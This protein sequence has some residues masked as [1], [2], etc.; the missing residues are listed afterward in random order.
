MYICMYVHIPGTKKFPYFR[1]FDFR[2]FGMQSWFFHGDSDNIFLFSGDPFERNFVMMSFFRRIDFGNFNSSQVTVYYL[3]PLCNSNNSTN[4][5]RVLYL[6]VS[7]GLILSGRNLRCTT[8][9]WRYEDGRPGRPVGFALEGHGGGG[10]SARWCGLVL[11]FGLRRHEAF[12]QSEGFRGCFERWG[13]LRALNTKKRDVLQKYNTAS[14]G[15]RTGVDMS[16]SHCMY[17]LWQLY[18]GVETHRLRC[19]LAMKVAWMRYFV[20]V[21]RSTWAFNLDLDCFQQMGIYTDTF[22]FC[23]QF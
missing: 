2:R 12:V 8:E 7:S 22:C 23:S 3:Y 17:A 9:W 19:I 16:C 11:S 6:V 15:W 13:M 1:R 20:P 5:L 10:T 14:K 4:M 21:S 18:L